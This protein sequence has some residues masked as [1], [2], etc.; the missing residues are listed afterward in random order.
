M[1]SVDH[2]S[3][4]ICS[5]EGW[6]WFEAWLGPEQNKW[7]YWQY[8]AKWPASDHKGSK[9]H[10][11]GCE[12]HGPPPSETLKTLIAAGA[13]WYAVLDKFVEEYPQWEEVLMW[14]PKSTEVV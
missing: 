13:P 7:H 6:Y 14:A 12:D 10:A 5:N 9:L 1:N 11:D 8:P 3:L 2:G 4:R